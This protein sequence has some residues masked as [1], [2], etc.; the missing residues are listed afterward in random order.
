MK[1]DA[2][3]IAFL[4]AVELA[5]FYRIL[6]GTPEIGTPGTGAFDAAD[7]SRAL[8]REK[9]TQ[10]FDSSATRLRLEDGD[11]PPVLVD[12]QGVV[13]YGDKEYSLTPLAFVKLDHFVAGLSS[14]R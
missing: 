2:D 14:G 1:R 4:D 10:S 8:S 11:Q 12:Q 3:R 13:L 7:F 5:T 9:K 6:S